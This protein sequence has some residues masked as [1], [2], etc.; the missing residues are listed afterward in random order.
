ME[1]ENQDREDMMDEIARECMKAFEEKD[2]DKLIN[3][4]HSLIGDIIS[5]MMED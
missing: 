4:L 2:H 3:C 5:S 1:N